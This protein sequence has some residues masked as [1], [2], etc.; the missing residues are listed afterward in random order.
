MTVPRPCRSLLLVVALALSASRAHAQ[1][2]I[3]TQLFRPAL[4]SYGIFTVERAQTARQWAFGAQ[5]YFNYALNPLRLAMFDAATGGPKTTA[6]LDWQITLNFGAHLGLTHWLEL[7]VDVP[8]S[9]QSY[10]AAYGSHGPAPTLERTGF[11]APGPYTNIGPPDAAPLDP[12]I[13]L[14]A[15]L[16]RRGLFGMAFAAVATLPFGDDSAFLGNGGF[17][18]RPTLIAD[19]TRG[20]LT[21]ALNLGAI[22]RP[23]TI[24]YDPHEVAIGAA[25]PRALIGVGHE[26]TW[27]AGAAYRFVKWVALA[28]ELYGLVPLV[29]SANRPGDAARDHTAEIL[30]GLQI[31]P[32][33]GLI[34]AVGAG[35]NIA[36]SAL[37]HD[38]VR[39]FV[40][41]TWTKPA[42]AT[43]TLS[44][45]DDG[46]G[47]VNGLDLCPNEP[48]DKDGFEDGDGC[49]DPDNDR[50]GVSDAEDR[51]PTDP[52][53]RDA[54]EDEDGCPELDNDGDG[55]L[56]AN[57][58]CPN[59]PEDKDGFLDEDGCPELDNDGDGIPDDDD[60]CPNEP[61]MFNGIHDEDGCP[62][63]GGQVTI[64][65]GTLALPES[66]RF[67]TG[68]DRIAAASRPLLD[69][70]ADKIKAHP[71]IRRVRIEGHADDH[72]SAER[73]RQLSQ[74]RA[75]SVRDY[76][77]KRGVDADRLQAVGYGNT[78]PLEKATPAP[79][80]GRTPNRRVE[81][82]IVDQ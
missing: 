44:G 12:R 29:H 50:D 80:A 9:A 78:R 1:R 35:A 45:D 59:E 30:G 13:G 69:G 54:F 58:K 57:D 4:D 81:F 72:R 37:R 77:I 47:I 39:A 49:P 74:R 41:L 55:V 52:E 73:N 64:T 71:Q 79:R 66:I 67:D 31:F 27:S 82:I 24:V 42:T 48:E 62:D 3:D 23:E 6:L 36:P 5:V 21:I 19:L 26:L 17:T 43:P 16:F 70:V 53:D 28:A 60:K 65:D 15:R 51:C 10:T 18:F 34:I 68:S 63:S 56:D 2:S 11:Y 20:P 61:E 22:V 25:S 33:R 40:G 46:D 32:G 8:L 38:D 7:V 76:L 14:K 75:E